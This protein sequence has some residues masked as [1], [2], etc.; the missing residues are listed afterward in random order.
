[1]LYGTCPWY[2]VASLAEFL[3]E[4]FIV[5]NI[6]LH[7]AAVARCFINAPLS[8]SFDWANAYALDKDTD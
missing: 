7:N 6:H 1:M 2:T 5:R 8:S 3:A 4:Q